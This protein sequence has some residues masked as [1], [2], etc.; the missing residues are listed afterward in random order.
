MTSKLSTWGTRRVTEGKYPPCVKNPDRWH[1]PLQFDD[2][3]LICNHCPFKAPCL[4][5]AIDNDERMGVWGGTIP[6]ERGH[7]H[8]EDGVTAY[9]PD[10]DA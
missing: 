4:Q 6:R 7:R 10:P 2:A 8:S 1:D 3:I 9:T 5:A